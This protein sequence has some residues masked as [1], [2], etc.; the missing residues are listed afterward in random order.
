MQNTLFSVIFEDPKLIFLILTVFKILY[1]MNHME[2][3]YFLFFLH[4]YYEL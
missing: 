3:D 1:L 4:F 2:Q